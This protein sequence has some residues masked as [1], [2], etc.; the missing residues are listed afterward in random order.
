M[1]LSCTPKPTDTKTSL[2]KTQDKPAQV[3]P[4]VSPQAKPI[5]EMVKPTTVKAPVPKVVKKP[6]F[7]GAAMYIEDSQTI[8]TESTFLTGEIKVIVNLKVSKLEL[9]EG[10]ICGRYTVIVDLSD[11]PA[12]LRMFAS[13][14]NEEGSITLPTDMTIEEMLLKGAQLKGKGFCE[15]KEESREILC[16]IEPA[17]LEAPQSMVNLTIDSGTRIMEFGSLYEVRNDKGADSASTQKSSQA[18]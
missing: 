14:K 13:D 2:E 9:I 5:A 3:T 4:N 8:V 6:D 1:L 17:S 15:E 7:E 12:P 11:V 10:A 16:T 18:N